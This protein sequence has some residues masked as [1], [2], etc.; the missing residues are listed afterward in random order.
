[1][2]VQV[3]FDVEPHSKRIPCPVVAGLREA[4][5]VLTAGI[6]LPVRLGHHIGYMFLALL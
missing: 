1:M 4:S 5:I 6:S 3:M 2:F